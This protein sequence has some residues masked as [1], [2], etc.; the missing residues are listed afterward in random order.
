M[1]WET[2]RNLVYTTASAQGQP[3][4]KNHEIASL[5]EFLLERLQAFC[6]ETKC[7]YFD[8][9]TFTVNTTPGGRFD[10]RDTDYFEY[11]MSEIQQV[12][13]DSNTLIGPENRLG[14]W[15][16][17]QAMQRYQDYR[18]AST[19]TPK[20]WF[21][22]PPSTLVL[23]PS[24]SATISNCF[25]SGWAMQP[26]PTN[27]QTELLLETEDIRPAAMCCAYD[28]I[29]PLANGESLQKA[30]YLR[31]VSERGKMEVMARAARKLGGPQRRGAWR[32]PR[33][34]L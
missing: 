9:V 34:E 7:L 31:S 12:V 2:F 33:R 30:E 27:D 11:P 24:P 32:D 23:V 16:A 28:L 6:A 4:I 3:Y 22:Y 10:M 18:T 13:I 21:V 5:N 1:T 17:D 25:V 29:V 19:G 14:K 15:S 8:K 20:L 26:E